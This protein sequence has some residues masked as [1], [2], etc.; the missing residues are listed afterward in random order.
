MSG[1]ACGTVAMPC[2]DAPPDLRIT[3]LMVVVL[4]VDLLKENVFMFES[5]A[6]NSVAVCEKNSP[7][8]EV[9]GQL[10][11]LSKRMAHALSVNRS[12]E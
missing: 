1:F 7:K 9:S 2:L 8:P 10:P 5:A 12:S 4:G 11:A 6:C 3:W